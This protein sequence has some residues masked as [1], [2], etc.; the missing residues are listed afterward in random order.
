MLIKFKSSDPRAGQTARMDSIRGQQLIDS[1][2]ALRLP[3]NES[4]VSDDPD[5]AETDSRAAALLDQNAATVVAAIAEIKD[6]DLLRQ[7]LQIETVGRK[8]KTVLDA[9]NAAVAD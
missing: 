2:A 6:A 3:E 9:L 8:R 4:A 1:G 5:H 7:A